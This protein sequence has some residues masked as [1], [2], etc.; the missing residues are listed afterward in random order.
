M[1]LS[2]SAPDSAAVGSRS[3]S[4]GLM[5]MGMGISHSTQ[6][7][8]PYCAASLVARAAN[9]YTAALFFVLR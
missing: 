8:P 2:S 5:G 1:I 6:L 3:P 9:D 7:E 4:N